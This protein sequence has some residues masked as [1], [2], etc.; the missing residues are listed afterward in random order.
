MLF[1]ILFKGI[2]TSNYRIVV[3]SIVLELDNFEFYFK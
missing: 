3:N 2:G 1:K